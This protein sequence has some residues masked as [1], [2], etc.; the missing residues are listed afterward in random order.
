MSVAKKCGE[1]NVRGGKINVAEKAVTK[2]PVAKPA[3]VKS[4]YTNMNTCGRKYDTHCYICAPKHSYINIRFPNYCKD[5]ILSFSPN[6]YLFA[7]LRRT[8]KYNFT[9][10]HTISFVYVC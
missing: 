8:A 5:L 10:T 9:Y 4:K 2:S 1:I 7:H 6:I 3:V